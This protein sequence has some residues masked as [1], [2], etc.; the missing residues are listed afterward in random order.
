MGFGLRI[1]EN[2]QSGTSIRPNVT[3]IRLNGTSFDR[4]EVHLGFLVRFNIKL[5]VPLLIC[6]NSVPIHSNPCLVDQ[7]DVGFGKSLLFLAQLNL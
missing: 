3:I 1:N 5:E 2:T 7:M 6:P 4:M